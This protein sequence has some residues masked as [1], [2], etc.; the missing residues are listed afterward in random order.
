MRF[1]GK[2]WRNGRLRLPPEFIGKGAQVVIEG[3]TPP[4]AFEVCVTDGGPAGGIV[5]VPVVVRQLLST[6]DVCCTVA[7]ADVGANA[8]VIPLGDE[9]CFDGKLLATLRGSPVVVVPLPWLRGLRRAGWS[10]HV[11]VSIGDVHFLGHVPRNGQVTVPGGHLGEARVVLKRPSGSLVV[12]GDV[13]SGA[14]FTDD[15]LDWACAV[16]DGVEARVVDG[17]LRIPTL[18]DG[19][20]VMR[21]TSALA[22]V[23]WAL[24][25]YQAEG[26]KSP[27]ANDT[28]ISNR[29]PWL[30]REFV[31]VFA[32]ELGIARER[33]Y[34]V[35]LY[36]RDQTPAE[37]A[38]IYDVVGVP[39]T[40]PRPHP[41][42]FPGD[43]EA[44][45]VHI[46]VSDTLRKMIVAVLE[47]LISRHVIDSLPIEAALAFAVGF[48]D[49][50]GCVTRTAHEVSLRLSGQPQELAVVD[51]TLERVFGWSHK[52]PRPPNPSVGYRRTLKAHGILQLLRA[53]AF[54]FNMGRARL[55]CGLEDRVRIISKLFTAF[56]S[57]P[58]S[59]SQG[60]DVIGSTG[61]LNLLRRWGHVQVEAGQLMLTPHATAVV[62]GALEFADE[63]TALTKLVPAVIAK[64][65]VVGVKGVSYP[66]VRQKKA[67]QRVIRE[68]HAATSTELA[69]DSLSAATVEVVSTEAAKPLILTYEWLGTIGQPQACYGLFSGRR[70]CGLFKVDDRELLGVVCFGQGPGRRAG[71]VCGPDWISKSICLTRGACVHYAPKDAA[72]FLIA[73]AVVTASRDRGWRIFYAFADESAGEIGT[74]Y[75]ACNWA[76]LGQGLGR[77]ARPIERYVDANGHVT[78]R[79]GIWPQRRA[80]V[81]ATGALVQRVPAKHK[82]VWFSGSALERRRLR[83][84][85]RYPLDL[86]YPKR[87]ENILTL[88]SNLVSTESLS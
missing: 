41:G 28:S 24:G 81:L 14:L 69:P 13:P 44:A 2:I 50:D 75:Q 51:A 32:I 66:V 85:C 10:E 48:L 83:K 68:R 87:S 82:Y 79:R 38:R 88:P 7:P 74:V 70:G 37:A 45:E 25:L 64:R 30:L 3:L 15:L 8:V 53:D 16:P 4:L 78:S 47:A 73:H 49:G 20:F 46:R 39:Q 27:R 58:F 34:L 31:D 77:G 80:D 42:G 6:S 12:T 72:S 67:H 86:P 52:G 43:R 17:L 19:E 18:R 76:Y 36:A 33:F 61:P 26:S 54:R 63:L 40:T 60:K 84:L 55:L 29:N 21:Q 59:A 35:P 65:G 62:E 23:M 1:K 5:Q 11:D 57:K 9:I 56:G 22:S 71:D